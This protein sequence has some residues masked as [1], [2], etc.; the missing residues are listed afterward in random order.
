ML[1]IVGAGSASCPRSE[2]LESPRPHKV[3]RLYTV[4]ARTLRFGAV[5]Q[6]VQCDV[7]TPVRK[8]LGL[9][10]QITAVDFLLGL[11]SRTEPLSQLCLIQA[12]RENIGP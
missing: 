10:S 2:K 12:R 1:A 9:A 8:K 5:F 4:T 7:D 11:C 6:P 3:P